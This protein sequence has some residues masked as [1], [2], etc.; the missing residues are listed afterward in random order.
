[1]M[2]VTQAAEL[3]LFPGGDLIEQGLRDLAASKETE[4]SLLVLVAEP[5]L[6]WLGIPFP[7]ITIAVSRPV[8]HQL[9]G[10]LETKY[11]DDA[12]ARYNS[13]LRRVSSFARALEGE[14]RS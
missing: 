2:N 10:L 3:A 4:L 13:L 7:A 12:Y 1:M 5:R 8:E 6:R 14:K 9:Y 11:G